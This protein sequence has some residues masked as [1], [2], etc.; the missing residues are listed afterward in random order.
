MTYNNV[1]TSKIGEGWAGYIF[2]NGSVIC[3][4]AYINGKGFLVTPTL[5]Y[6]KKVNECNVSEVK[7]AI[8]LLRPSPSLPDFVSNIRLH[9]VC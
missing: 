4:G 7:A 8:L 1:L 2:M 6:A 3:F 9:N 5:H